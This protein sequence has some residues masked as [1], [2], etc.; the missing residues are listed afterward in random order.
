MKK[1]FA[2]IHLWISLPF[3][4]VISILCLTGATLIF[5]SELLEWFQ[6]SRYKA[7]MATESPLPVEQLIPLVKQQLPD[8]VSISS[9]QFPAGADKNYRMGITGQGRTSLLVDPYTGEIKGKVVPYQKGTFFSFVRRLHRWFLFEFK[10]GGGGINW[11]KMITGTSTL[12]FVFVLLSGLVIWIPNTIKSLKRRLSVKTGKGGFRFWYD[13]HL[14]GG[15]YALIFLLAMSL[16]GLTWSF[17]WYRTGFYKVFGVETNQNAGHGQPQAQA[18]TAQPHQQQLAQGEPREERPADGEGR[19]EGQPERGNRSQGEGRP[20]PDTTEAGRRATGEGRPEGGS[21]RESRPE[22]VGRPEGRPERGE[23]TPEED[24]RH[25]TGSDAGERTGRESQGGED[26][27]SREGGASRGGRTAEVDYTQWTKI[28][29]T[30]KER[31]PSYKSISVQNGTATVSINRTGNTRASDRYT[32]DART[33][34]ITEVQY[35][36]D[37]DKS[38]KIRGWIYSVHVGS[39]GGMVT[40]ILYFIACLLGAALPLTGYYIFLKKRWKKWTKRRKALAV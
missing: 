7:S 31:N 3:G 40:R 4:L 13:T 14:A 19:P 10:R 30:L 29:A 35:Y 11:G 16:T 18:T 24:R 6:P 34:E 37:L 12:V 17:D 28:A 25:R 1:L 22:G 32:F 5:E 2:K 39:W 23:I 36:K 26:R 33:G 38:A 8:S 20:Q 27:S 9:V 21:G 15:M